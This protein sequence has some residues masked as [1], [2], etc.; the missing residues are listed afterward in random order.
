MELI[1]GM[2]G[3][4]FDFFVDLGNKIDFLGFNLWQISFFVFMVSCLFR[5]IFPVLLAGEGATGGGLMNPS[6]SFSWSE[7]DTVKDSSEIY[8][9]SG[10]P[11]LGTIS[12]Y[13]EKQ[14]K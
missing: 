12:S 5:W 10:R 13:S 1:F 4:T 9:H 14:M 11:E 7:A 6:V 3:S 2:V 8:V